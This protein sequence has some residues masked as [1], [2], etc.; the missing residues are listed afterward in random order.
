MKHFDRT[1]RRKRVRAASLAALVVI[2]LGAVGGAAGAVSVSAM[3][4]QKS[5]LPVGFSQKFSHG[6]S[7]G[8]T[9]VPG[10]VGHGLVSGWQRNFTRLQGVDTAALTSTALEYTDQAAAHRSIQSV[11]R[12]VLDH[13]GAKR[14][15][16]GRN[17]GYESRAFVYETGTGITTYAVAWRYKNIDAVVLLVGLRSIGVTE[18]LATRL[19]LRQQQHIHAERG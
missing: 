13:T 9:G 11:W 3:T 8:A 15:T 2:A 17:L 19:A 5:D 6:V 7:A 18:D 16:I 14:L 4:V 1:R 12:S 10:A